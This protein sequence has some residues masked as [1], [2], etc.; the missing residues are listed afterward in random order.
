MGEA[1]EA[2]SRKSHEGPED[3]RGRQG[4]GEAKGG[5]QGLVRLH[6]FAFCHRIDITHRPG[7]VSCELSLGPTVLSRTRLLKPHKESFSSRG[8]QGSQWPKLLRCSSDPVLGV[9]PGDLPHPR[10]RFCWGIGLDHPG[11][12]VPDGLAGKEVACNV[13]DL[14]SIPGS[15]RSPGEG[16]GY[17]LQDS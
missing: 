10:G 11:G 17:P 5:K 6:G 9:G 4:T 7:A 16:I 8:S 2:S 12:S 13:G 14:G 1:E 3:S 15:G